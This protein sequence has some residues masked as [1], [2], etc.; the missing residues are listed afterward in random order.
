MS[1]ASLHK[2]KQTGLWKNLTLPCST[3]PIHP[4]NP[5]K[6]SRH[7]ALKP[8]KKSIK[9]SSSSCLGKT[10]GRIIYAVGTRPA[11]QGPILFCKLDIK[12]GFWRMCV[13]EAQEEQFCYVLPQVPGDPPEEIRLVVPAALQMGWTSSPAIFCAA[14]ETGPDIA[15]WLR[16][17]PR[18]PPHSLE[19]HMVDP[20]NPDLLSPSPDTD[21]PQSDCPTPT[22]PQPAQPQPPPA[23]AN[24]QEAMDPLPTVNDEDLH[25]FFHQFEVYVDDYVGLL[26]ST[27]VNALRHHS[28]A[29]LHA[30]HQIFPPPVATGHAGEEPISEKKLILEGEGIWGTVK[31]MLAHECSAL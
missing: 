17:L 3:A 20:I 27:D 31:E 22:G 26:Q 4:P 15:E 30:I 16:K 6:P 8:W 21:N 9:V 29:L 28:R 11:D 12:D 14:T 19:S 18:L 13:P 24:P 1:S 5:P 23:P 25:H 2:H 7:A 10:L